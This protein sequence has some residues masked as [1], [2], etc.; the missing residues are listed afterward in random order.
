MIKKEE[1]YKKSL[2]KFKKSKKL[3]LMKLAINVIVYV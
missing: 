1:K 2:K 3:L